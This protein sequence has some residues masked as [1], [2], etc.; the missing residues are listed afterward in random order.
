[1]FI[2]HFLGDVTGVIDTSG[3]LVVQYA[4]DSWGKILSTTGSMANTVGTLNPIRYRGYYY[5]VETGLYYLQSRYYDPETGRFISPDVIA[6]GGNIY[7]YCLND[8]VNRSDESGYLSKKGKQ[9]IIIAASAFVSVAV[10][11]VTVATG[12]IALPVIAGMFVGFGVSA[13]ISAVSQFTSTGQIDP[14]QFFVDGAVGMAFGAL[15]GSS[16]NAIGMAMA[17][18]ILG[19]G[20]SIA[21]N[22]INDEEIDYLQAGIS[23]GLSALIGGLSG[24]GA[25][26]G[27]TAQRQAAIQTRKQIIQRNSAGGYRSS[28]NYKF[29]LN[30]NKSRIDRLTKNLK[31][32]AISE[33]LIST[34]ITLDITVYQSLLFG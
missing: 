5:D 10:V 19:A 12:G 3:N 11:T 7:T 30:S 13:G 16:I 9:G 34:Y 27:K 4:Y 32:E 20:S 14:L 15:G 6:E 1:M 17:S 31:I 2:N 24:G 22:W 8:P 29:A 21:N 23:G 26:Y 28:S 18:G 25:Q 33:V